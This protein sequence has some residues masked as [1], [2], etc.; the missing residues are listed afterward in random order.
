MCKKIE[1]NEV[2][3]GIGFFKKGNEPAP[4]KMDILF[5][6]CQCGSTVWAKYPTGVMWVE[7]TPIPTYPSETE[8]KEFLQEIESAR[9]GI[10]SSEND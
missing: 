9:I 6:P 8:S 7:A 5:A 3:R 1:I 10:S 2:E 4:I